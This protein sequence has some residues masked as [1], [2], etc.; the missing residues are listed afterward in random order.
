MARY[1]L[2]LPKMGE[3]VAEATVIKWVKNPGDKVNA[4]DAVMEIATDKVDSDVPSPVAGKL[5]EQLYKENDVVQVG[6]VIAIIETDEPETAPIV[7][8]SEEVAPQPPEEPK[9]ANSTYHETVPFTE[10]VK[11]PEPENLSNIPGIDQL[12]KKSSPAVPSFKSEARFYSPLVRNIAAQEGISINELDSIPGTGSEG[13]LTKDDLLNYLQAKTSTVAQHAKPSFEPVN[14]QPAEEVRPVKEAEKAPVRTSEPAPQPVAPAAG[15]A[16][17]EAPKAAPVEQQPAAA[18]VSGADEIIEM[19]RMRRLI[20]DHM[21]MSKQTSPHVTS[22][23]EADVT[24]LVLWREK[25]KNSF[26]KREGEKIT[27]TPIFIEAVAKAIKDFPMINVSVNGTQI[28]KKAAINISMATALPNGNLIV[29]VIKKADELN[30]VGLTKAVNDLANRARNGKLLPDDVKEGTFTITN[31]GSFGNV[32]GT[33]IIN[34][35]QVAILAVGAIK[36]KP[37]VIETKE[38]DMIAIRHMM[39]LSLSYDHRV[40]DGALGGSFVRRVADYLEKWDNSREV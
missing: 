6:A 5:V 37:A 32:M 38:G 40:V 25:V 28:I 20:A 11:A 27:F 34:Q 12:E 35:P 23:V 24:N 39:F 21:V 33:P 19:D 14:V 9:I 36:K 10:T 26:E 29:P 4:D 2:L 15:P 17:T 8:Q 3:S 30:L 1:Q 13:R 22:F 18:S 7:A 16:K 31:V